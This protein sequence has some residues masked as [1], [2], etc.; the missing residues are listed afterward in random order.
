MRAL[1]I[2]GLLLCLAGTGCQTK[3]EGVPKKTEEAPQQAQEVAESDPNAQCE[4][5]VPKGAC[6]KCNLA[7]AAVYKAQNN[8]CAEH[9]MPESFC[10]IC[11]PDRAAPSLDSEGEEV[12]I[13]ARIVRL[14]RPEMEKTAGIK[15][16]SAREATSETGVQCNVH[17][18]FN[19][20]KTADV[21]AVVPGLVR[22]VRVRV[23]EVVEKGAPLFDLESVQVNDLRAERSAVVERVRVAKAQVERM[24]ELRKTDIVSKR[25]L[26][27]SEEELAQ[28]QSA[29]ASIDGTLRTTGA[30]ASGRMILRA[31]I[32]GEIVERN[33]IQG[34]LATEED[35]LAKIVDTSTL[36]AFCDVSE[37]DAR[38]L[39]LGQPVQIL[40]DHQEPIEG[41]LDWI[42]PQID[43][44]SR[45]VPTRAVVPNDGSL[46]ANQF[47]RATIYADQS[48][49]GVEVPREALQRV[50]GEFVVFVRDSP[51]VF[52]PRIVE[53]LAEGDWVRVKG[54]VKPGDEV[55]TSGA[56]FLRTE[57]MPGSIGAGCCEIVP[58]GE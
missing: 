15:T 7:L 21:R 32:T 44:R 45:T 46:R 30:N 42:S 12:A 19:Q 54:R 9:G 26:E 31:P 8:W 37:S 40:L 56:V 55:V 52:S 24:R 6:P 58:G 14:R 50:E 25:A 11:Y 23:G 36:W 34:M 39:A 57:V 22:N 18:G 10:P 43:P 5:K 28:S 29:L 49:G 41:K 17:L 3:G 2:W 13:E 16:V 47:G 33:A 53:R 51:G 1:K 4:H 35:S 48:A 20:D 38:G 27:T